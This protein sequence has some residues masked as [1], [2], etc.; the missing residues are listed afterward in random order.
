MN[1]VGMSYVLWVAGL[2]GVSGLHRFYNG[3]IFTGTLWFFTGGLLGIGQFVDLF[4][5]PNMADEREAEIRAK[6]G[7]SGN[8]VPLTQTNGAIALTAVAKTREELMICLLKAAADKGGKLSVTQGVLATG[9]SFAEVE[10]TFKEMLQAGYVSVDNDP[11]T[12][13]VVFEFHELCE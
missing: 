12:G 6:L 10:A 3:K 4:L 7:V 11:Q 5:I 9:A 1:R 8:G 13:V 2:V